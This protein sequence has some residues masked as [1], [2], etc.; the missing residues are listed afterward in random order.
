MKFTGTGT[1][2]TLALLVLLCLS[3]TLRGDLATKKITDTLTPA[4]D[5]A[6]KD[7]KADD[8]ATQQQAG[9]KIMDSIRDYKKFGDTIPESTTDKDYWP[10]IGLLT[11]IPSFKT[12]QEQFASLKLAKEFQANEFWKDALAVHRYVIHALADAIVGPESPALGEL[13]KI[14]NNV[15][16]E[17]PSELW[18]TVLDRVLSKIETIEGNKLQQIVN[19]IFLK[20]KKSDD[21]L[22]YHIKKLVENKKIK[23]AEAQYKLICNAILNYLAAPKN[24][25][26]IKKKCGDFIDQ[27]SSLQTDFAAGSLEQQAKPVLDAMEQ[28]LIGWAEAGELVYDLENFPKGGHK[29]LKQK[30]LEAREKGKISREN[31]LKEALT[32]LSDS[33]AQLT[34][35][36]KK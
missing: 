15:P 25:L 10:F 36:L 28:K 1:Q 11:A 12:V 8:Q 9:R 26:E 4:L 5:Q 23:R 24:D 31:I 19:T 13:D 21:A 2:V 34:I 3:S 32:Q 27:L 30:I 17:E 29:P 18:N 20:T 6:V 35:N 14:E 16:T 7:W 22:S 33:F